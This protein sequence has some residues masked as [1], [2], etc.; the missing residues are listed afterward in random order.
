MQQFLNGVRPPFADSRRHPY[1][2]N[3]IIM[4][5][6]LRRYPSGGI[7]RKSSLSQRRSSSRWLWRSSPES[8]LPKPR[9]CHELHHAIRYDLSEP[10]Q[11]DLFH[12]GRRSVDE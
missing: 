4:M 3:D 10:D 1:N 12:Y 11:V 9:F 7:K 8:H 2:E 5:N 6:F